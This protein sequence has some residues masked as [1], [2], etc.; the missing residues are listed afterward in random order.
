MRENE[1][2]NIL[3]EESRNAFDD[4]V[5]QRVLGAS[6]HI[7]MV[8]DMIEALVNRGLREKKTSAQVIDE[9]LQVSQYFIETR[10][11]A[12]Q[13]VSNAIYLMIHDIRSCRDM[14]LKTAAEQILRTK[15]GYKNTASEAVEL[16]VK[17][18]VRLAENME[19]IFVYD[20]SSTVEK[21]LRGL[22]N[23]D[24]QYEIY[25]AES[26]IID[27]GRPF[28]KACQEAGH[29]IKFI[30]DASIMYYLRRCGAAF[31]GAETFYPDGTGFNTT[32][33]DIVGLVCHYFQI[34]LYFLTPMIKLDIRPVTGEKKKLVY[35]DLKEKL[36][37]KWEA[38][39][40]KDSID[41]ITPELVGVKPEFIKAFVTE[42]G[43]IPSGQMYTVSMEYS[44]KLRGE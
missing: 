17:Y 16:C 3:P 37:E 4:I 5:E 18:A 33:S 24:K 20:Y 8:G 40:E 43:V 42:Q 31:M 34:P 29:K 6:N 32:G 11:E 35:D 23:N 15:N 36:S 41:F 2:R 22:K 38:E 39:L 19:R 7:A 25:I 44:R 30:P 12:S 27:G 21:F 1:I 28:V 9:I 14:D 10:G 26:R 13:A